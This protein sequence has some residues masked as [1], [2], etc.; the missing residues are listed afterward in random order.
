ML[1][2]ENI[3]A[4][5]EEIKLSPWKYSLHQLLS[6]LEFI[7][8]NAVEFGSGRKL[9][10]E[11]AM[12][13]A[14]CSFAVPSSDCVEYKESKTNKYLTINQTS[15]VGI[16]G[17]LPQLYSEKIIAQMKE[18]NFSLSDFLN[19][20]HQRF[21]GLA[22][23]IEKKTQIN[24]NRKQFEQFPYCKAISGLLD[25]NNSNKLLHKKMLP[26][27][28][29]LL[30]NKNKNVLGLKTILS[31]IFPHLKIE[32]KQFIP[33][34]FKINESCMARLD[35]APLLNKILG[36]RARSIAF[37]IELIIS[38]NTKKDYDA[39]LPGTKYCNLIKQTAKYYCPPGFKIRYQ[40]KLPK[41]EKCICFLLKHQKLGY[42][43][44]VND[45][46]SSFNK[47]KNESTFGCAFI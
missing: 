13:K 21:F 39:I 31:T 9:E 1:K 30:W 19:I 41:K 47:N 14:Y 2:I 24:L 25:E 16:N 32:I 27:F 36:K 17:I 45:Y 35:K 26:S 15:L 3:N 44:W 43:T 29:S 18:Q 42:N 20:F 12:L 10:D 6:I 11:P 37:S 28:A 33:T 40:L 22:H 46:R 4:I 5:K 23:K 38:V 8:P 34:F 7:E